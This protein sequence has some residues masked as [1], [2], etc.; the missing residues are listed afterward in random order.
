MPSVF[1]MGGRRP[2][3]GAPMPLVPGA[4]AAGLDRNMPMAGGLNPGGGRPPAGPGFWDQVA[5]RMQNPWV[6]ALMGAS[7]EILNAAPN[8]STGGSIAAGAFGALGAGT[9]AV[10]AQRKMMQDQERAR[11]ARRLM[12]GQAGVAQDFGPNGDAAQVVRTGMQRQAARSSGSGQGAPP[13]AEQAAPQA[14]MPQSLMYQ[15]LY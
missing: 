2:P 9:G 5:T 4:S 15:G 3:P 6:Q 14:P 8:T 7:N 12:A 10:Q 11:A 13:A 1:D